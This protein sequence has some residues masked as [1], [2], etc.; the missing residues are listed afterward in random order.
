M[1]ASCCRK[2]LLIVLCLQLASCAS[3]V[4]Y[5]T[6]QTSNIGSYSNPYSEIGYASFYG[7]SFVGKV[8]A[9]GEIYDANQL[10]AAHRSLPFGTKLKVTNLENRQSVVVRVNDRGP[11]V[12]GR[13]IDLSNRAAKELG[14]IQKG[15]ARVQIEI[16]K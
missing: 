6:D 11:F 5:S 8:T 12:S 4:R 9:S 7:D 1:Q 15:M 16:V 2:L 10:T 13:I 14:I 3:S